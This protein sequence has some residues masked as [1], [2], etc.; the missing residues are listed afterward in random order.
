M[1]HE[2]MTASIN[3][4]PT[5]QATLGAE[6]KDAVGKAVAFDGNG[7]IAQA[8]TESDAFGILIST[9]ST[10]AQ[11]GEEVTVQIRFTGLMKAGGA[12]PAGSL[13]AVDDTGCAIVAEAGDMIFGR[14]FTST[15]EAGELF[16]CN[17]T[18]TGA[19]LGATN[20]AKEEG[21][22]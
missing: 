21:A 10:D 16:Q 18:P 4:S 22:D 3:N 11:L 14:A 13:V 2:Y 8:T 12:I 5:I 15:T 1:A 19:N 9:T 6:I 17:I 7:T 20:E